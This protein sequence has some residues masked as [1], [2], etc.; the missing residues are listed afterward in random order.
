[1][2][3]EA[4]GT[5]EESGFLLAIISIDILTVG[6]AIILS[7]RRPS[8]FNWQYASVGTRETSFNSLAEEECKTLITAFERLIK[9]DN[10]HQREHA[11]LGEIAR[12]LGVP[13]RHLSLSINTVYGESYS[14]RM[15]RLRVAE[16]K[17]L[18][19]ANPEKTIT[20]I[21]YDAGFRT[22]SRFN[23]EFKSFEGQTPSQ[24]KKS[25]ASKSAGR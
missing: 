17:K 16:A 2:D 23:S 7:L 24:Y 8:L 14:K 9:S 15:N 21:M 6:A 18:M 12:Q 13:R 3:I 5:L 4:G 1:M 10:I 11:S 20:Q 22:K 25:Q 19:Q